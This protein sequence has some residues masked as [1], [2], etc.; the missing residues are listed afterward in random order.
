LF[1]AF[2]LPKLQ[3]EKRP[4]PNGAKNAEKDRKKNASGIFS[5]FLQKVFHLCG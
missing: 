5:F 3:A 1:S 2:E 4:T